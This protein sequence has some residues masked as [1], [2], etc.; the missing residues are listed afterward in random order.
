MATTT[1]VERTELANGYVVGPALV[2]ENQ[3]TTFVPASY[4]AWLTASGHLRMQ[5]QDTNTD[6]S[7]DETSAGLRSLHRDIMWNRLIAVVQEQAPTLVRSAF[8]TSTREAGDLSA[9]VFDSQEILF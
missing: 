2:T 3:T 9:G 1:V 4:S 7:P 5:G 6:R 8:S